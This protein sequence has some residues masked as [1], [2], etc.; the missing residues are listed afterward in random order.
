M[1]DLHD[2]YIFSEWQLR[3]LAELLEAFAV[4]SH[5]RT[6][7]L[8]TRPR[9]NSNDNNFSAIAKRLSNMGMS[10]SWAYQHDLHVRELLYSNGVAILPDRGLDLYKAPNAAGIRYC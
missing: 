3:N 10:F 6:V 2:P 5:V 9:S 7:R 8:T 1:L 4:K